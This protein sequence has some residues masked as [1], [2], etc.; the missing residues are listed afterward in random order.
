MTIG[1][2]LSTIFL[3]LKLCSIITWGWI[4]I[5]LPIVIEVGIFVAGKVVNLVIYI[6]A[7]I[8]ENLEELFKD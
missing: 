4:Y 5:F 3:I 6:I 2:I 1:L 8:I 7:C